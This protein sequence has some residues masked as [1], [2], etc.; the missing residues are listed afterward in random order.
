[1]E[2]EDKRMTIQGRTF[3]ECFEYLKEKNKKI[4]KAS[5]NMVSVLFNMNAAMCHAFILDET[6]MPPLVN[7]DSIPSNEK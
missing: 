7:M 1:M 3:K 6:N 2:I 5:K 4:H